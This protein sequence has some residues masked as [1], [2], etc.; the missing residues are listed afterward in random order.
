[1][2]DVGFVLDGLTLAGLGSGCEGLAE[3]GEHFLDAESGV[4]VGLAG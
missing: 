3:E 1:M 2:D 4:V